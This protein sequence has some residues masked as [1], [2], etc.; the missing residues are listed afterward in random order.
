MQEKIND[1]LL[2][3]GVYCVQEALNGE[4][5]PLAEAFSEIRKELLQ[6]KKCEV[7]ESENPFYRF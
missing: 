7:S 4:T 1:Y 3:N 5:K 2:Y 6:I